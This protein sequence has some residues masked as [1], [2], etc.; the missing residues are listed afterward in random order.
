[1]PTSSPEVAATI[2]NSNVIL[3]PL[4]YKTYARALV[5]TR[6]KVE[7]LYLRCYSSVGLL[8]PWGAGKIKLMNLMKE[9]L[10]AEDQVEVESRD[11]DPWGF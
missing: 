10:H 3:V 1:M 4:G 5:D 2:D 11:D 8:A 6:E 7:R 9:E